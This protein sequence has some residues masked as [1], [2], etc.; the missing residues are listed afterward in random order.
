MV[1]SEVRGDAA[2]GDEAQYISSCVP[3]HPGRSRRCFGVSCRLNRRAT[4]YDAVFAIA[5]NA[6]NDAALDLS[7][8][9]SP[10][11]RIIGEQD[12]QEEDQ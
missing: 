4:V 8:S 5:V 2:G 3:R 11:R 6:G 7:A 9:P 1:A 10:D 12:V